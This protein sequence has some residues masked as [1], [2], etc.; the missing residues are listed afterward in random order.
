M[1]K[2]IRAYFTVFFLV[3]FEFL[4]IVYL[5]EKF[6]EKIAVFI[7]FLESS[8]YLAIAFTV[9]IFAGSI[10]LLR[11][12]Y[13]KMKLQNIRNQPSYVF[14]MHRSLLFLF[15]LL[16][17]GYHNPERN[18]ETFVIFAILTVVYVFFSFVFKLVFITK[19]EHGSLFSKNNYRFA[20]G[21]QGIA[22]DALGF[23]KSAQSFAEAMLESSIEKK[24][25]YLAVK[26][27]YGG[28]GIEKSSFARMIVESVQKKIGPEQFLYTYISLTETNEAQDFSRL[29]SERWMET[30]AER[31][32]IINIQ[33]Y[34][35]VLKEI[36]HETKSN[37][38]SAFVSLLSKY[39][40]THRK[41]RAQVWDE[42]LSQVG[43]PGAKNPRY[44][45]EK[46]ASMFAF[47][48]EIHEKLWLIV[49]DEIERGQIDEIHRV[50]EAI[51]RFKNEGRTGLPVRIVFL[52]CISH[53]DLKELLA[54]YKETDPRAFQLYKFFFEDPKNLTEVFLGSACG[55]A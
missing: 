26:A 37:I 46:V 42:Y 16:A 22:G 21:A 17:C 1:M 50:V 54:H 23:Y 43:E 6:S 48:P 38:V 35:P 49:I 9:F 41:T 44:V 14:F 51:E 31:Y 3:A 2:K 5:I 13:Q 45:S 33:K 10:F 4:F 15:P 19:A 11:K 40:F 8:P 12:L 36:F 25:D 28:L 55:K 7:N 32:P 30:L 39:S 24:N 47:I 53:D 18:T 27:L 34:S 29:F 52:L 20:S